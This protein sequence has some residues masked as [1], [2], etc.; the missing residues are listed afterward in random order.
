MVTPEVEPE[1]VLGYAVAVITAALT[2]SAVVVIPRTGARLGET[3]VY[4]PFVLWD[5][6]R[7]DTPIG[8]TAGL[9]AAVIDAAVGLL[10]FSLTSRRFVSLLLMLFV[11]VLLL[12]VLLLL[13]GLLML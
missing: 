7:V 1:A 8:R 5:S 11:L 6:A 10:R 12:G 4:L 9:D 13:R 3:T 2:P